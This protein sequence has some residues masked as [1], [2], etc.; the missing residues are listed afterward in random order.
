M[1]VTGGRRDGRTE[2]EEEEEEGG[3]DTAL[4]TKTPHVN[5]G[6]NIMYIYIYVKV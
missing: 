1:R 5:V 3:A 2:E 4:K 6:K